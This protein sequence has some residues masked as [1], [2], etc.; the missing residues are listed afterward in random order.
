MRRKAFFV[1][2]MLVLLASVVQA[3]DHRRIGGKG[4]LSY[5][6]PVL[7]L[8]KNWYGPEPKWGGSLI[9]SMNS[10]I[11]LEFEYQQTHYNNGKIEDRTFRW[12][13]DSK[14]Y[15][16]PEASANMRM[17]SGVINAL[18]RQGDKSG[19]FTSQTNS[20]YFMFGAGF[21]RYK[22]RVNGL[23]YPGQRVAPLDMTQLLEPQ[24]DRRFALGA[25]FGV[26]VERF[27]SRNFS[28]DFRAK[29]NFLVGNL[30]PREAWGVKEAWPMQMLDLEVSF[31]FYESGK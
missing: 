22:N 6:I 25:S 31:K 17:N 5:N 8:Q 27:L 4:F 19:L 20:A 2:A 10:A 11:T 24:L 9:Y 28:L 30:R 13:V 29:Y 3:E 18:F 26:G 23:V 14:D 21:H 7:S 1:A 16:S 15:T 12:T